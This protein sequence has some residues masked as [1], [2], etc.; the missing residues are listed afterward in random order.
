[1]EWCHVKQRGAF[2]AREA[3]FVQSFDSPLVSIWLVEIDVGH[4]LRNILLV[5]QNLAC[6]NGS[7]SLKRVEEMRLRNLL[8]KVLDEDAILLVKGFLVEG[9]SGLHYALEFLVFNLALV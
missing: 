3:F 1:M 7:E 5:F 8:W 4:A 2:E 9:L 6:K